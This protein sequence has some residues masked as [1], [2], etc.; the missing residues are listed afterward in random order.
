MEESKIFIPNSKQI[1]NKRHIELN[2]VPKNIVTLWVINDNLPSLIICSNHPVLSCENYSL[3][4]DIS[5]GAEYDVTNILRSSLIL[6]KL[7]CY[8]TEKMWKYLLNST[9]LKYN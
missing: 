3:R 1:S 5:H 2:L 7:F 8:F 9:K 6:C 4:Y